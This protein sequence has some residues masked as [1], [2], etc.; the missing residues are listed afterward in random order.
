[1]AFALIAGLSRAQEAVSKN[2]KSF[3]SS[4]GFSVDYPG[5]W[6]RKG[7]S[8]DEL[9]ILSS[10]G[11]A[12][13]IVIKGGQAVISV[14]EERHYADSAL[15]QVIDH[16]V[17]DA[18][19]LSR[20]HIRNENL[21]PGGCRELREIVSKEAAVPPED[22]PGRVPYIIDTM[23]FCEINRHKYVTVLRNFE[24]D[25]RQRTYR[26]IALRVAESLRAYE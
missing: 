18:K 13:A 4:T 24:G 19:V 25:K 14:S 23:Y 26:Q 12:E 10:R 16:Y 6:F 5:N 20:R 7:I 9:M 8:T 3:K 21:G 15:S 11:G 1:M 2:W 17:Q 22:V